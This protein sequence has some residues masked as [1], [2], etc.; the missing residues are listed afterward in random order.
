MEKLAGEST[1]PEDFASGGEGSQSLEEI[2]RN[3]YR[4]P[5]RKECVERLVLSWALALPTP[6]TAHLSLGAD[7]IDRPGSI[8]AK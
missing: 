1:G 8:V 5:L 4:V 6:A 3:E 7:P 2:V